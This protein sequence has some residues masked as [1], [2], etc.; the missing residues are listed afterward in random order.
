VRQRAGVLASIRNGESLFKRTEP[1]Y[2]VELD[3]FRKTK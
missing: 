3:V 2:E 1:S